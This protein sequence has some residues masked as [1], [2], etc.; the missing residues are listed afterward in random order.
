VLMCP[1]FETEGE[2]PEEGLVGFYD[3]PRYSTGYNALFDRIGILSE[4]HMLKPYADRVN[5]T[6][7]LVLGTLAAMNENS[8][9]LRK[10]RTAAKKHTA[11]MNEIGLNWRLDT[12]VTEQLPWKGWAA[13]HKPSE[14]SGLPRLY[15]DHTRPTETTVP[16]RQTYH[17][18]VIKR[19][20][21][22]YLIPQAWGNVVD[23]L[24]AHGVQVERVEA[25]RTLRVEMD[26][27]GEVQTGTEPYEGHY[28]HRRVKC[29]TKRTTAKAHAGDLLVR[30]GQITD[31]YIME[32]LEPEAED[33]FFAWGMFDSVLQQ[34]EWFSD[35]VF[36]DMA[37]E[38]LAKDSG[39][40]AAL[41]AKRAADPEFAKDAWAQLYFVYAR[42]PWF[43]TGFRRYPVLRVID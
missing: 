36:E 37:A 27:I 13:G 19:K 1:Y 32:T 14:V 8:D 30:T 42:S 40:K 17:A 23:R 9:A 18:S 15:Y 35:Y 25:D 5:A 29:V 38:L 34:K 6:F 20:P 39:L 21:N 33:S 2:T 3:S 41:D 4:S 22:A 43:E 26:S 7:Q 31:R 12:T 16:W 28:L 11:D 24:I 10:A